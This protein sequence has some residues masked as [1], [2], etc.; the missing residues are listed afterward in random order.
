M[1]ESA[2][3]SEKINVT[4]WLQAWG[5]RRCGRDHP[6]VR[7]AW[8]ILADTVYADSPSAIYEVRLRAAR[9][10]QEQVKDVVALLTVDADSCLRMDCC[11]FL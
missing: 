6:K 11:L 8:S 2:W 10:R 1:L 4:E 9:E 7:Q 5:V 3:R